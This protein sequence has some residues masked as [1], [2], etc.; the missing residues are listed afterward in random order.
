[1]VSK[2]CKVNHISDLHI[3]DTNSSPL[4]G[5]IHCRKLLSDERRSQVTLMLNIQQQNYVAYNSIKC[6]IVLVLASTG[7]R[8]GSKKGRGAV[9][10]GSLIRRM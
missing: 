5:E 9:F 1:M 4:L 3:N 6:R 8:L 10:S 2:P 7:C